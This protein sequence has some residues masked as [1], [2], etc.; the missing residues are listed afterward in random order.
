[1]TVGALPLLYGAIQRLVAQDRVGVLSM[2]SSGAFLLL[3]AVSYVYTTRRGKF[4]AWSRILDELGLRGDEAILD[5]GCGR[6]AVLLLAAQ[7]LPRGRATGID[8]WQARDQSGNAL[9]VTQKN[10]GL[11]G[12]ADRIELRTG[13]MR[14]LPFADESFDLVVSSLALHNIPD[15]EG[16]AR[17][18][19]EAVRVLRPGGRI[20]LADFRCTPEYEAVLRGGGI[21]DI[22]HDRL[23]IGFWYGGPWAATYHV[24]GR[25]AP[26][27]ALA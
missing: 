19:T 16:R 21:V 20:V 5:L 26:L 15:T 23:G 24:A 10:A 11:E 7:R 27:G 12:V 25:R 17:A 18:V 3:C 22:V 9:D 13:D 4:E 6:G 14:E 1:M 8:L 2:G